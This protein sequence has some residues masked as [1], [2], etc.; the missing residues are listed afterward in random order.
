ML[1]VQQF[2]QRNGLTQTC[3]LAPLLYQLAETTQRYPAFHDV[4]LGGNRYYDAGPGWDY[5]SGLGSPDVYN[6]ARDLVA[7]RLAHGGGCDAAG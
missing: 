4:V 2:A 1:L 5:A 6:L 7:R 3:F